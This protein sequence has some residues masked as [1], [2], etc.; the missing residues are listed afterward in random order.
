MPVHSVLCYVYSCPPSLL[1]GLPNICSSV[2]NNAGCQSRGCEPELGQQFPVIWQQ[3][4]D[5]SIIHLQPI[6][7]QY[8]CKSSN[9]PTVLCRKAASCLE[10]LLWN[11]GV[12]EPGNTSVGELATLIWT[13]IYKLIY[14]IFVRVSKLLIFK[15]GDRRCSFNVFLPVFWNKFIK[16]KFILFK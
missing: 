7:Q 3:S 6:G 14:E 10:R 4:N 16:L 9:R 15:Q 2:G 12:R 5:T 8:M 13:N 11:T 1:S